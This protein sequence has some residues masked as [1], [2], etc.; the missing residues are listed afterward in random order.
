MAFILHQT[1]ISSKLIIG[2]FERLA[3]LEPQML[4]SHSI[5][6]Q[7]LERIDTNT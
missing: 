3:T 5:V 2:A 1:G 4:D 6:D 7:F